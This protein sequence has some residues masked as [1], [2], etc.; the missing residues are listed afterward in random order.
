[1]SRQGRPC[2]LVVEP[3]MKNN[4]DIKKLC[5]LLFDL[6]AAFARKVDGSIHQWEEKRNR[7]SAAHVQLKIHD[8]NWKQTIEKM[9]KELDK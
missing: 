9:R 2:L 6:T 7:I 5:V 3:K 1:M 8:P 4:K